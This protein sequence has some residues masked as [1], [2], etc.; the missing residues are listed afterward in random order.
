MLCSGSGAGS[1]SGVGVMVTMEIKEAVPGAYFVST[2][3]TWLEQFGANV[4][5][6]AI[7]DGWIDI[8]GFGRQFM[9]YPDFPAD[10]KKDGVM[11]RQKCCMLCDKCYDLI[12]KGHCQTGCVM[13]DQAIYLPLY[14]KNVLKK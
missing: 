11:H 14:R 1:G 9:A 8:G 7:H 6:G 13:R 10:L 3:M 4:T 5:A 12:Q 2:G